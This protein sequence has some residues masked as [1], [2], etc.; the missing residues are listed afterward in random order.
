MGSAQ[1]P[2]TAY[3]RRTARSVA[4]L[5]KTPCVPRTANR[6]MLTLLAIWD[7]RTYRSALVMVR[8]SAEASRRL[9]P[10]GSGEKAATAASRRWSFRVLSDIRRRW[11]IDRERD[12]PILGSPCLPASSGNSERSHAPETDAAFPVTGAGAGSL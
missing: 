4:K 5:S 7:A 6:L 3:D 8:T 10:L 2:S 1:L 12:T 9:I 11:S